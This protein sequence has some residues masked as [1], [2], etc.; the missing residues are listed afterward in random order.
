MPERFKNECFLT[1]NNHVML[2]SLL[3]L[4][5]SI[6]DFIREIIYQFAKPLSYQRS[7]ETTLI[8]AAC[9]FSFKTEKN[10]SI[11]NVITENIYLHEDFDSEWLIVWHQIDSNHH[12]FMWILRKMA[13]IY[14]SDI[15]MWFQFIILS[16]IF[17][18]EIIRCFFVHFSSI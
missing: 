9:G 10:R 11:A 14:S 13:H 17:F 6:L 1:L 2:K 15:F 18:V 5:N 16:N 7:F 8:M 4:L 3:S 12:S